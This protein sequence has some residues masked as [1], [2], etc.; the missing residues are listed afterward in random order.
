MSRALQVRAGLELG[1]LGAAP[2]G[3]AG[4]GGEHVGQRDDLPD[5]PERGA[6]AGEAQS[7]HCLLRLAVMLAYI[8]PE[9]STLPIKLD[10]GGDYCINIYQ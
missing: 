2:G 7:R 3:G 10:V 9:L 4:V 8:K 6:R 1:A 5:Q